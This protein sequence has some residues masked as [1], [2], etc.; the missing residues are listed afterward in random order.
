LDF[1]DFKSWRERPM[2]LFREWFADARLKGQPMAEAVALATAEPDG[3]V[4]ARMVLMKEAGDE[5]IELYTNYESRKAGELARNPRAALVFWWETVRRQVRVEGST[6]KLS[7]ARSDAYFHS[8]ERAS[9]IGAWASPQSRPVP[10]RA[11]LEARYAAR[12]AEF[13]GEDPPRPPHWGGYLLI[14][15]RLEF[16]IERPHRLHDRF[17]FSRVDDESPWTLARLAP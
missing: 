9:R 13:S 3:R 6:V 8:R 11:F 16:W 10:D 7:A 15:D 5:G 14:P 17:L 2:A 4:S 12:D 1:E